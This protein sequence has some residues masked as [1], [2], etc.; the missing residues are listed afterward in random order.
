MQLRGNYS[1]DI[2]ESNI[3]NLSV[4]RDLQGR[5]ESV[6]V[7]W[8]YIVFQFIGGLGMHFFLQTVLG[9]KNNEGLILCMYILL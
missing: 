8:T 6:T 7:E 4:I 9:G 2:S 5:G 1:F 3:Q